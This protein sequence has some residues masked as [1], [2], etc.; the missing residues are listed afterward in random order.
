MTAGRVLVLDPSW[1]L[2]PVREALEGLELSVEYGNEPEGVDVVGLLVSPDVAVGERELERLP[3]LRAVATNSTGF[4]HLDVEALSRAGVWCS[5]VAGYCTEEMAEHTI[6]LVV[7][8]LRGV[9]ELDRDVRAGGWYPYAVEPRRIAGSTLGVVGFGRIGQAVS[10]RA[11][12]LGMRVAAYDPFVPADRIHAAGAEPLALR[13]LLGSADAVTLHTPLDES[14]L[15]LL[16]E[17]ELAAMRPGAFLVNCSRAGLV[18]QAALGAALESGR[19]GGA[20]L[21]VFTVEPP[22][23]DEPAL[24]W[25]RTV[26]SPHAAWYSPEIAGVPYELAARDLAAALAGREPLYALARPSSR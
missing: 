26:V 12:A 19:L 8:L 25:P 20:A 22:A 2:D 14:T 5:N 13:D 3:R 17:P 6:A 10:R 18:D 23:P 21:D 1:Q 9:V 4:D 24:A 16:S 11:L 7:A 15:C